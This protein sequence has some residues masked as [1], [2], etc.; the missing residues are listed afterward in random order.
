MEKEEQGNKI[1]DS[2]QL[3]PEKSQSDI[4]QLQLI[5]EEIQMYPKPTVTC[6]NGEKI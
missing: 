3:D 4:S 6:G 1:R 5:P 2:P